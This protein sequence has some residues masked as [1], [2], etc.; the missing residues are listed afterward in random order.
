LRIR[1][2]YSGSEFSIP[3]PSSR[4][5]VSETMDPGSASKNLSAFNPKNCFQTLWIM[6]RDVHPDPGFWFFTHPGSRGQKDT[7]SRTRNTAAKYSSLLI[8]YSM[9]NSLDN[10][11]IENTQ[12]F[13]DT[14]QERISKNMKSTRNISI[15]KNVDSHIRKEYRCIPAV[16]ILKAQIRKNHD[17]P[18]E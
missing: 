2:V 14:E 12:Q 8:I 7:G 11:I 15:I 4:V 16:R 9:A 5:K 6:T 1:D 3:D 17:I 18:Q 10:C 13:C